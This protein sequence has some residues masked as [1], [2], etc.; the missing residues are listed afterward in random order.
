MIDFI[1]TLLSMKNLLIMFCLFITSAANAQ[2]KPFYNWKGSNLHLYVKPDIKSNVLTDIPKG[3][4]VQRSIR[5][6]DYPLLM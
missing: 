5:L 2:M 3:G 4:A 6:K 1:L